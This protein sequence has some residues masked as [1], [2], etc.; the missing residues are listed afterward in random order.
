[1]KK[2]RIF[3][4]LFVVAGIIS[5]FYLSRPKTVLLQG[6]I[7]IRQLNISPRIAGRVDKI[8]ARDLDLFKFAFCSSNVFCLILLKSC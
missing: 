7:A 2:I 3:I 4:I 5:G 1:M 6:E 8:L